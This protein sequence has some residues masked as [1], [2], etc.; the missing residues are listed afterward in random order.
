MSREFALPGTR[1]RYAPDRPIDVE[2]YLLDVTLDPPTRTLRGT[3]TITATVIA[4]ELTSVRLDAVELE[5]TA[6]REGVTAREFTN[7]G[8]QLRVELGG[9]RPAGAT[10][11]LAIDYST[12]PRRGLYFTAPDPGYPDKPSMAWTQGQDE[13]SRYWFPCVDSPHEKATSEVIANV[14]A[15]WYVIS[16]GVLQ[17]DHL[18][19]DRRTMH[20]RLDEPHACY[21][22]TLAAG[23]LGT[24]EDH[25]RDVPVTYHAVRG[26]EADA[27]RTLARTPAMLELFSQRFGVP[28]PFRRYAQVFVADFIFGGM[29]NTSATTL[30]DSVLLDERAAIDHDVDALVAH[31]L[32]HQWFGDLVTCRDWGEGWLNEGFATYAEYIWREHHEGRD[33]A[34]LELDEWAD[35]YFGEDGGRYRRTIATKLTTSR[36]TSSITTCTRRA[37]GCCT[38]C[39]RCS[40]TTTTGRA[41]ATTSASTATARSR[42]AI[43]RAPSRTPPAACST[44]SSASG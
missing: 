16:N 42:P 39:G 4:S 24:V 13:D 37:G 8:R 5:I 26:R 1:S 22:I 3:A 20:W 19:G 38:C 14:P 18:A 21:L 40:A 35:M 7:D 28:Y 41:C 43:W 10:I 25:W 6:V 11:K 33:A 31:E 34:D 17:D 44:G 12:R 9:A 2:H 32:A 29:E 36:S 27:K 23:E 30:T 15:R